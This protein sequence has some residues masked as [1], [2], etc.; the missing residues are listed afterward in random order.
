VFPQP[1]VPY[2]RLADVVVRKHWFTPP[3][4]LLD[5]LFFFAQEGQCL[6][7]VEG[8]Q[9]PFGDGDV[10]FIQPNTLHSLRGLTGTITPF[11]HF[12]VFFNPRR[13]ESFAAKGGQVNLA[14]FLH[15][16][17]PRLDDVDGIEI[18]V[19][20]SPPHP[21]Q[22]QSTLLRLVEVWQQ[23]DPISRLQADHLAMELLLTL[24]KQH[25]RV[26]PR[27]PGPQ[28]SLSW[29]PSYLSFHLGEPLSVAD[30]ADR[31]RLSPS[32]FATVFREHFGVSP[33]QYFLRLRIQHAQ[34]LL[35]STDLPLKEIA[36][37]CGFADVHHFS[38]TFKRRVQLAPGAFRRG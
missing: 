4:R 9:I 23:G 37:Y 28:R 33:H 38:K 2:V 17:Q 36:D 20:L 6:A 7:E 26:G 34:D 15:L 30:M 3:R 1:L 10:I 22:F 32:R 27:R 13:D 11:A 21:A 8:V 12:D 31:A 29:V 14:P 35:R 24:L 5:Y 19:K 18:P 16:M 25:G